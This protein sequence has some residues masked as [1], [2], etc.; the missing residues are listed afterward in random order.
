M[1]IS[2][3]NPIKTAAE[4]RRRA[5]AASVSGSSFADVLSA[6]DSGADAPA[7]LSDITPTAD[8]HTMLALQEVSDDEVQRRQLL[9]RGQNL[10]DKLD[11]LRQQLLLGQVTLS[12]LSSLSSELA[13]HRATASDPALLA[14][15]DD[16]ELR[17]A[18]EQAKLEMAAKAQAD[19]PKG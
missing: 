3:S 9:T 8:V 7:S 12:T 11:M 5:R 16:I 19:R 17:A 18:V 4:I 14:L 6:L 15:L 2:D 10:L 13:S 1:R